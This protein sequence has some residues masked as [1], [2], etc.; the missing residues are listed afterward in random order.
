MQILFRLICCFVCLLQAP[1]AGALEHRALSALASTLE[2]GDVVFIQ[3]P[4]L[5]FRKVGTPP[6]AGPIMSAS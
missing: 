5:L 2:V 3:V 6:V 4:W 1:C